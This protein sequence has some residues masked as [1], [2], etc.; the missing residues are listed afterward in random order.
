MKR[1][2]HILLVEDSEDDALL[3]LRELQKCGYE[4]VVERVETRK[5]M[6]A[7]IISQDWD[8]ILTDYIMPSFSGLDALQTMQ[9]HGL[10]L[11]FIIVS[12]KIGEETAVDLMRPA[13]TTT[14]SRGT[15][16]GLRR[17]SNVRCRRRRSAG[18]EKRMRQ[19]FANSM[20][21][22]SSG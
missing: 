14:L 21:N 9:E 2:L 1:E 22:L 18:E 3:L 19:H 5:E 12:G 7:A 11:P 4:P 15:W 13:P 10:D 20:M 16:H 6:D 17:Q 8:V